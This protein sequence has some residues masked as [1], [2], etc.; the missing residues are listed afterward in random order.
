[1]EAK[2]LGDKLWELGA[3]LQVMVDGLVRNP[4]DV[5]QVAI[6]RI[7]TAAQELLDAHGDITDV[8]EDDDE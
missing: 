6:E 7:S 3:S 5:P 8:L 1:M 4:G 2:E